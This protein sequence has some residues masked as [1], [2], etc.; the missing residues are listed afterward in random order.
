MKK[1]LFLFP[2]C[3]LFDSGLLRAQEHREL[4]VGQ[5]DAIADLRTVAGAN[6][7]QVEWK[8]H[9]AAV[10]EAPFK[11]P[12]PS[13]TDPLSLYPTGKKIATHRLEP[14]AGAANFDDSGWETLDP[15]TLENRRGSG[16]LSFVWYRIKVVLPENLAA[17]PTPGSTAVLEIVA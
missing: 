9:E 13:A 3:L 10:I 2:L 17:F 16:L 11:S 14:K 5:P 12:G 8:F 7:L 1:L 6:A 15:T 4:A